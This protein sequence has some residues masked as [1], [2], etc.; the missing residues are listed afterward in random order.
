MNIKQVVNNEDILYN[1]ETL[2]LGSSSNQFYGTN[3]YVTLFT[4]KCVH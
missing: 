2:K 1:T 4:L 3:L